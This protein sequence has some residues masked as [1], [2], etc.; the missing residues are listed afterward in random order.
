MKKAKIESNRASNLELD[1]SVNHGLRSATIQ[2]DL[3]VLR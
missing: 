1:F 2:S 3:R